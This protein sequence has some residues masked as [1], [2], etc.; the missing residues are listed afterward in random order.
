[1]NG[2][3]YKTLV[4]VFEQAGFEVDLLEYCDEQGRFHYNEWDLSKG[5]IYRSL[6]NDHRNKEGKIKYQ[7]LILTVSI[8]VATL[9]HNYGKNQGIKD[10]I[11]NADAAMYV[12]KKDGKNC[13]KSN[14]E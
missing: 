5:P 3:D 13:I 7:N 10:L 8:G 9:N 6:L 11:K 14:S 12:A 1:M 4:E 2:Y